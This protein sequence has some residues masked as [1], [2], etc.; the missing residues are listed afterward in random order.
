MS[1]SVGSFKVK[2]WRTPTAVNVVKMIQLI[3][4]IGTVV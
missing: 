3:I 4:A 2:Q 1:V